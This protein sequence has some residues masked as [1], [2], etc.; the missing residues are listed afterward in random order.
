MKVSIVLLA[1]V[2]FF[3]VSME[4]SPVNNL[5]GP[6]DIQDLVFDGHRSTGMGHARMKR[7]ACD[8][9]GFKSKWFT[10][11]DS[12]CAA[13]CISLGNRGGHCEGSVCHCRK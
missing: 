11:G 4:G 12:V 6:E 5:S 7:A 8:L 13:H 10:P 1:V 3:A 9:F 2:A